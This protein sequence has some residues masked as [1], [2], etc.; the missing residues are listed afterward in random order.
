MV[1]TSAFLAII[2]INECRDIYNEQ[3]SLSDAEKKK[4]QTAHFSISAR[5]GLFKQSATGAA[6]G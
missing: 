6:T 3:M 4:D 1:F 2:D 5:H